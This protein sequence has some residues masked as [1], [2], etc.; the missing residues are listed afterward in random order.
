MRGFRGGPAARIAASCL[1]SDYRGW[2]GWMTAAA[3]PDVA[4]QARQLLRGEWGD[5]LFVKGTKKPRNARLL[6]WWAQQDSNLRPRDYELSRVSAN[7]QKPR[8][9]K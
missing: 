2:S 3:Q 7:L 1:G 5:E 9:A 6:M 8:E 4:S